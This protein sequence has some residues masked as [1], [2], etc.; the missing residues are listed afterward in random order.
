MTNEQTPRTALVLGGGGMTGIAWET[1]VLVGLQ[2][3]GVDL[4]T[5]DLVIGT[6]AGSVVGAQVTSGMSLPELYERQLDPP[7]AERLAK[8]SRLVLARWVLAAL[9]SRGDSEAFARRVGRMAIRAA[10]RGRTP[11]LQQR[12]TAIGGR[13]PQ[14]AW[15]ERDLRV[16]TVD[17]RTGRLRVLDSDSGVDLVTAVASSCAVPGVYPP[18]LIDG[19]PYIDGGIRS[20]SNV[21]L[22]AGAE[23][24]VILSPMSRGIGPMTSAR[25]QAAAWSPDKITLVTPDSAA[26]AAIGKNVLDPAAQA[27]SARAG[28]AQA[29]AIAE[30]VRAVWSPPNVP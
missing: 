18:V 28:R 30:T 12:L 15:P 20:G 9:V 3:A 26:V 6:S 4:S 10:A 25:E 1:G 29:A 8:I 22:A 27:G 2:D 17:A 7:V 23:R 16:T 19:Q 21:D 11:T 5:A 14:H 24:V 13:L